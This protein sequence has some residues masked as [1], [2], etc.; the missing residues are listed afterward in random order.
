MVIDFGRVKEIAGPL[1]DKWDHALIVSVKMY[2]NHFY[3]KTIPAKIV[4]VS[5]NPTAENMARD[6]FESIKPA[7]FCLSKVR[8]HETISICGI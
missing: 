5:Y 8:V 4:I 2:N 3:G 7:L 6:L 1:I